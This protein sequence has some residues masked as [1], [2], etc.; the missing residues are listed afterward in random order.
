MDSPFIR[1]LSG[2]RFAVTPDIRIKLAELLPLLENQEELNTRLGEAVH[3]RRMDYLQSKGSESTWPVVL[4]EL[5]KSL[6]RDKNIEPILPILKQIIEL[7]LNENQFSEVWEKL[8]ETILENADLLSGWQDYIQSRPFLR[9]VK[10]ENDG[11]YTMQHNGRK[12]LVQGGKTEEEERF[13]FIISDATRP[14]WRLNSLFKFLTLFAI[15]DEFNRSP[16]DFHER[17]ICQMSESD[18]GNWFLHW[19]W[20]QEGATEALPLH[21]RPRSCFCDPDWLI[22]DFIAALLRDQPPPVRLR[23]ELS[24]PALFHEK[25][26]G[27]PHKLDI[28][29]KTDLFIDTDLEVYFDFID[30]PIR[31]INGTGL[32]FPSIS[33]PTKEEDYSD[34]TELAHK[35][36]AG[37]SFEAGVPIAQI[38]SVG[39][40]SVHYP[41]FV[42]QPKTLGG[43]QLEHRFLQ[44]DIS[45]LA[46][47]TDK[48]WTALDYFHQGINADNPYLEFLSYYK[49]I[50]MIAPSDENKQKE[51]IDN[52]I[53]S[54]LPQTDPNWKSEVL[55][56]HSR[57]AGSYLCHTCRVKAAHGQPDKNK[58]LKVGNQAE[59]RAMARDAEVMQTLARKVINDRLFKV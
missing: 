11:T 20:H 23:E 46:E 56:P 37:L 31:W 51:W 53:D 25:F 32:N 8:R 18:D 41:P 9:G 57:T 45:N 7:V 40:S 27:Y 2:T 13:A 48:E 19:R 14:H 16:A 33:V 59:I 6:G 12:V 3:Q 43:L 52:N 55:A 35:F 4:H 21:W 58:V 29:L 10:K 36:I 54:N 49:I 28:A 44:S 5:L 15:A 22:S 30:R 24:A 38:S 34:S 26:K 42:N 39:S 47:F 1:Y 50:D 17:T